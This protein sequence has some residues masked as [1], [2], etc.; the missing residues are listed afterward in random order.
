M[1]EAS[2]KLRVGAG[3]LSVHI[4]RDGCSLRVVGY[5]KLPAWVIELVPEAP[6]DLGEFLGLVE[7]VVQGVRN[8]S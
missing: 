7:S 5:G 1:N 4:N 3:Y 8:D 6:M 2:W